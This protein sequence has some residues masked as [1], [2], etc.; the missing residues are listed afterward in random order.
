[1][2][3][4]LLLLILIQMLSVKCTVIINGPDNNVIN[5]CNLDPTLIAEIAS[6]KNTTE[7]IINEITQK[8][9]TKFFSQ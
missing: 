7:F 2:N 3:F 9:G 1:M 6:Y 8:W 5:K 4:S